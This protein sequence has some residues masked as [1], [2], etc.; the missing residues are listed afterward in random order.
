[1]NMAPSLTLVREKAEELK[2]RILSKFPG[3]DV[4]FADW[5][6][7]NNSEEWP[8][9]EARGF[10]FLRWG[11][12]GCMLIRGDLETAEKAATLADNEVAR[13]S[14]ELGVEIQVQKT[15]HVWCKKSGMLVAQ[16]FEPGQSI[17]KGPALDYREDK[18]GITFWCWMTE[19]HEHD[20]GNVVPQK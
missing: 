17:Q 12:H 11:V 8:L 7:L 10:P 5:V 1:M 16:H 14:E 20:W 3:V 4:E 9:L 13:I 18:R 15:N 19:P 6:R 2:N